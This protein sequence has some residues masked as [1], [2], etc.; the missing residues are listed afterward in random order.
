MWLRMTS[1]VR[2]RALRARAW[3]CFALAEGV[4]QGVAG[5]AIGNADR[6]RLRNRGVYQWVRGARTDE[7]REL[8]ERGT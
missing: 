6:E 4:E 8:R 3:S 2:R 7:R 1:T 5:Q